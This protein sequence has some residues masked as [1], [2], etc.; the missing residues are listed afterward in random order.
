M[1]RITA[2]VLD[3]DGVILESNQLKTRAFERVFARFPEHAGA[4]MAYHHAH[5][6][7]SRFV[8]FRHLVT[9]CLGRDDDDPLVEELGR[10]FS[11]EMRRKMIDCPFVPGAEA[12]LAM[13]S[14]R[15]PVFLASVTPEG[16]LQAI[17][18]QRNL[19]SYFTRVYGCPPWTKA[20]ALADVVSRHGGATGILFV[21][22]SAGDQRA[23]N[24]TGVEFVARDSGLPFDEPRPPSCADMHQIARLV[25][26]RL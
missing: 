16:E 13:A 10:A 6:S 26:A 19:A 7:A 23:A 18:E 21:G 8:K 1:S 2:L 22:D 24:E 9:A 12:F 25:E 11:A 20:R 15:L 17:L 5:M 3:F 14:A 4:M